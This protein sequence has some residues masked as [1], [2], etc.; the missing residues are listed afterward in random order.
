MYKP[1]KGFS[2]LEMLIVIMIVS[3][4][5]VAFRSSFQVKNKDV[6]YGQACIETLYG[7]VNNFLHAWLSSKSVFTWN[8]SV[9]PDQFI[10]AFKPAQQLIEL[11]YETQGSEYIYSSIEITGNTNTMYCISSNY[12]IL[13][14]W[15]TYEVHINKW[16]QENSAL[17]FFYLSVTASVSTGANIFLQCDLQGTWCR[18]MARF[19]SDT[20]II[21]I[22]KQMC[23]KF[24][25][26][27]DCLEWDN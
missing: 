4:L 14:T 23:L 7:Q 17:Q 25:D 15:D 21:S 2:F 11:K 27:G 10:I 6:L 5:F 8:V 22:K 9:F 1:R 24:S 3:I 19:E 16:L 26:T 12:M 20:R 18:T 13:L